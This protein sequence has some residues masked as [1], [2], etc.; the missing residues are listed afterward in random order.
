MPW[1]HPDR[2]FN[3]YRVFYPLV[4][5][6][7]GTAAALLATCFNPYR[8]FY[9]LVTNTTFD[10]DLYRCSFNPYRVFY[11]LVTAPF[12]R[13]YPVLETENVTDFMGQIMTN[14]CTQ[15]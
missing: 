13:V 4:T 7:A 1:A 5:T 14:Y 2:S 10:Q 9:P 8:V 6:G 12:F 3:P 15:T 11:P